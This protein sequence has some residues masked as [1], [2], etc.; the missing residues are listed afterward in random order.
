MDER[1]LR[2]QDGCSPEEKEKIHKQ[3][4]ICEETFK[5]EGVESVL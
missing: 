2:P 4:A 5:K 1:I 3:M